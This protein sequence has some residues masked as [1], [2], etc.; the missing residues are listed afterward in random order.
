MDCQLGLARPKGQGSCHREAASP[1]RVC[2]SPEPCTQREVALFFK[3]S[4]GMSQSWS[5]VKTASRVMNSGLE[6]ESTE[7]GFQRAACCLHTIPLEICMQLEGLSRVVTAGRLAPHRAL[8]PPAETT[9][10]HPMPRTLPLF[11]IYET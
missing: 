7:G 10:T 5:D 6:D 8:Q 9:S 11:S 2:S 4:S 3:N 1:N